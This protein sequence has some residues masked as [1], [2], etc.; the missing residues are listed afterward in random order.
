MAVS[1]GARN[2]QFG[3]VG[4]LKPGHMASAWSAS[5]YGGLGAKPPAVSRGRAPGGGSGGEAPLKL[6]ALSLLGGPLMR[7]TCIIIGIL[8][9]ENYIFFLSYIPT[10][11]PR[12]YFFQPRGSSAA[13]VSIPAGTP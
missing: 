11:L 5:L 10:V 1:G 8:Q 2:F 3:G 9:S 13:F 12:D 7:Q 6:K 4:G